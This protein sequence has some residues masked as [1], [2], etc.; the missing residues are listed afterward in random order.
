MVIGPTGPSG[1]S[2]LSSESTRYGERSERVTRPEGREALRSQVAFER[3]A[4]AQYRGTVLE[5]RIPG[6]RRG[7]DQYF[8]CSVITWPSLLIFSRPR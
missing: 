1:A 4:G 2:S 5:R 3:L 6:K 8:F 7:P